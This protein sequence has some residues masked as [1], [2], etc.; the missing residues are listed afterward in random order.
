MS[1]LIDEADR[2]ASRASVLCTY[3]ACRGV[4]PTM[5]MD[6]SE[7]YGTFVYASLSELEL[8]LSLELSLLDGQDLSH[9]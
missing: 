3:L 4:H 5:L 2:P 1:G 7:G 8:E 6:E 9:L